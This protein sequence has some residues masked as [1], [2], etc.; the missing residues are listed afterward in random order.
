[1]NCILVPTDFS[2]TAN[3]AVRFAIQLAKKQ[4]SK[5]VFVHQ[6]SILEVTTNTA[7]TGI[8]VPVPER[9]MEAAADELKKNVRKIFT[10]M[11]LKMSDFNTECILLTGVGTVELVLEAAKK[12]KAD[13]IVMGTHGAS[14]FKKL[15]IGSNAAKVVE[16]SKIPVIT[17]PSSFSTRKSIKKIGY[18][19]DHSQIEKDLKQLIPIAN[20]LDASI[21]IFYIGPNFPESAKAR[22]FKP[23]EDLKKIGD[24]LG[25]NKLSYVE[26][27]TRFE[28]DFFAGVDT[29]QRKHKPDMLYMVTKPRTFLDKLLDPSKSKEVAYHTSIPLISVKA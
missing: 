11:K 3:K 16:Q 12:N 6:I 20:A 23:A 17:I 24:K 2:E 5:L 1:M 8:Y 14:G 22:N 13:L 7:F 10:S 28:N 9:Q 26:I 15:I 25:F 18:A 21:E 19:T 29:Y 4:N 27:A